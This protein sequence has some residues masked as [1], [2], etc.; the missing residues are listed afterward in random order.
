MKKALLRQ[1]KYDFKSGTMTKWKYFLLYSVVFV[2]F[3]CC[4]FGGKPEEKISYF[5]CLIGYFRGVH[6][7]MEIER[8]QIF[9]I[10]MEWF[11][12]HIG[13]LF[14][15]GNYPRVEYM[16]RGYQVLL[17]SSSKKNWWISKCLWIV[18]HIVLYCIGFYMAIFLA[19]NMR[20]KVVGIEPTKLWGNYY[21]HMD[22]GLLFM[23]LIFMPIMVAITLSILYMSLSFF[24]NEVIAMII[25]IIYLISSVYWKNPFLIGNYG[26]CCRYSIMREQAEKEFII[27]ILWMLVLATSGIILGWRKVKNMEMISVG[28]VRK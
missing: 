21:N 15:V 20:G 22:M 10:P 26:M 2:L 12:F 25:I 19:A 23:L 28:K 14:L 5:D 9:R 4:M 13:Y 18:I 6:E 11:T 27:G 24:M 3:T 17:R 1:I 7:Y 8:Q 16:D